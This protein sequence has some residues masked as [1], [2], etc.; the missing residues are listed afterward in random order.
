MKIIALTSITILLF[1]SFLYANSE[2]TNINTKQ[3]QQQMQQHPET[4]LIDIRTTEEIHLLG[5]IGLYQNINIPRGWLEFRIAD[6]VLTK[7]TPIVVY[8]GLNQR[9]PLATK[10]L[11]AMGYSNVKNYS[12]GYFAWQEAGLDVNISDQAPNSFLYSL[13]ERVI[14]NVYTAIGD[15]APSTYQNSG[16]NN[17]LS[18]IIGDDAVLVFNAGGSYLL[19]KSLHEEIKKLTDLPVKFVV[20]ENAQGHAVLGTSYWHKQ[21][22]TII[23]HKNTTKILTENK[24]VIKARAQSSLKDKFFMSDII[25]PDIE[26]TDRLTIDLK[27]KQIELLH[28]GPSHSPD[29]VQLWMPQEKLLISGDIAFNIRMLPVLNHTDVK[30]WIETWDKLEALQ[31]KIIVPGHGGVTDLETVTYYTKDYLVFLRTEILKIL[32]DGGGMLEALNLDQTRFGH[33]KTYN[34]LHRQNAD[35]LFRVMEFE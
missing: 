15:A 23:G 3:L 21:G 8:C 20:L 25:L 27:G 17:N 33:F 4:V 1:S 24:E 30:G 34:E 16:H 32:D 35:R 13:P 11:M 22:A 18:F 29:D 9:S 6:R 10:Q 12:E 2:I 5:T 19:A 26:F 28:L 14:D 7:D 31:P